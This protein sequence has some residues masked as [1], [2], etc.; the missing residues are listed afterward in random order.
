MKENIELN[1][2]SMKD[3][4]LDFILRRIDLQ[5]KEAHTICAR[6]ALAN[7]RVDI[8]EEYNRMMSEWNE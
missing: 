5:I 8:I 1:N 3:I 7:F 2:M 6:S 4:E